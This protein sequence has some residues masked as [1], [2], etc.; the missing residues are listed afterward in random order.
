MYRRATHTLYFKDVEVL[1]ANGAPK[2]ELK[3][4]LQKVSVA[5]DY[6]QTT[7]LDYCQNLE[8]KPELVAEALQLYN[9]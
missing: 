1:I 3:D 5:F 9:E 8:S 6:F 2:E 4:C 7:H